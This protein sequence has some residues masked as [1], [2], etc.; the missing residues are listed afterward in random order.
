MWQLYRFGL[1]VESGSGENN[2][3]YRMIYG[4]I[5][6]GFHLILFS[7]SIRTEDFKRN[8]FVFQ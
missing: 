4:K 2:F 6:F 1:Y 5:F 3:I 7:N 8:G